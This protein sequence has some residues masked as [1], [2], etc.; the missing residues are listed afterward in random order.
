M[1]APIHSG[2]QPPVRRTP[3]HDLRAQQRPGRGCRTDLPGESH[4]MP[5]PPQPRG[6]ADQRHPVAGL[7]RGVR[8][9]R[10]EIASW[11]ASNGPI[12]LTPTNR[13][14]SATEYPP[15]SDGQPPVK[16]CWECGRS[17]SEVGPRAEYG[18]VTVLL[19]LILYGYLVHPSLWTHCSMAPAP[20][21]PIKPAEP[22]WPPRTNSSARTQRIEL[23]GCGRSLSR[24]AG[25]T[26]RSLRRS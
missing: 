24:C 11:H 9:R 16:F 1:R 12:Q 23:R 5:T 4:G 14:P 21:Q 2:T 8:R 22:G 10:R 7:G 25:M 17:R 13:D 6:P 19:L 15:R 26:R 20:A 18:S 3:Q